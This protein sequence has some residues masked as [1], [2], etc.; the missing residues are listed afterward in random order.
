LTYDSSLMGHDYAPYPCWLP[1]EVTDDG[2][3][4]GEPT[5][6]IEVPVS[7]SLDDFPHLEF[8]PSAAGRMPG[9]RNP[10]ELFTSWTGELDCMLRDVRDDVL[11]SLCIRNDRP[12]PPTA[13]T[14][15][16]AR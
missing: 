9:L 7:R 13:G 1:D 6:V 12:W 8:M 10:Q 11:R 3:R 2:I 4:R 15:A 5:S 16:L 14:R